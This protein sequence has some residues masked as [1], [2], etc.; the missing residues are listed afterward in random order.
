MTNIAFACALQLGEPS[1]CI[2]LLL[3]T[4]RAPEAALFARTYA[5]SQVPRAVLA[6]KTEVI[7]AKKQKQADAIADPSVDSGEFAEWEEALAREAELS[8]RMHEIEADVEEDPIVEDEI[9]PASIS[10]GVEHLSL[11]EEEPRDEE[12]D[13]DQ[14]EFGS[15]FPFLANF[16]L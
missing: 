14:L 6:W 1:E 3:S 11:A 13:E 7:G 2:D 5:P 10:N 12:E 9:S 8:H 16:G 4:D 15:S